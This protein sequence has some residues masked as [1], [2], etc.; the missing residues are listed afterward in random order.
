MGSA[1]RISIVTPS[2]NQGSFLEECILSVL[3][4]GYENLEYI[5]IDGGS[6]DNSL[7]IIKLYSARLHHWESK[8]DEG[9]YDA[10]NR[11]FSLSSGEIMGW[12]NA[13]DK[14]APWA[15]RV[16][17]E[18]FAAFPE[19]EWITSLYPVVWNEKGQ[20]IRCHELAGFS[21]RAFM[22]GGNLKAVGFYGKYFIQQESTFW[23]RSL[24]ERAGGA[25]D[26]S[27]HYA[28]DFELWARFFRH[29]ELYGVGAILG[30]FRVHPGQKTAVH[31]RRYV[32][33]ASR[34]LL[35]YGA[36]PCPVFERLLRRW[37]AEIPLS[38]V[39]PKRLMKR[40]GLI[41]PTRVIVHSGRGGQWYI[42]EGYTA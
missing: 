31:M 16:V 12:V 32:E 40:L 26:T 5:V 1:P 39:R 34:V 2:Y 38:L 37:L 15:L 24:W 36:R 35:R 8:K 10:I 13:D 33:E 29:A 9:Q 25:L 17:G 23:R 3:D 30:G 7:E 14:Y 18:I 21:R 42:R 4:Q 20:A 27:L 22:K 6:T 11:G 19:V 41:F 28:A